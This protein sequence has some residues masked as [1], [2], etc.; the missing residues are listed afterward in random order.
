MKLCYRKDKL[1]TL[2]VDFIGIYKF[3]MRV[4]QKIA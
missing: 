3:E 2:K 1:P 4:Q